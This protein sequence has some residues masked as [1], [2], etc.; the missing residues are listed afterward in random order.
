MGFIIDDMN[1][2]LR[3][4]NWTTCHLEVTGI[5]FV[6]GAIYIQGVIVDTKT[7]NIRNEDF[8]DRFDEN[9]EP[10]LTVEEIL[11]EK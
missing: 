8:H 1:F 5:F 7:G 9:W 10:V 2:P 11:A 4:K 6:Y 3:R